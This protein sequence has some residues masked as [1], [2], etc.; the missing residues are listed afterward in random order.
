MKQEKELYMSPEAESVRLMGP[1]QILAGS[2]N[3]DSNTEKMSIL[4]DD[5][6]NWGGSNWG[7][8]I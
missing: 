1:Q 5:F 6:S 7:G 2:N 8:L 3:V 4:P